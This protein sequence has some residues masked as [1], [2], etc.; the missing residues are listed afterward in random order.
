LPA[1]AICEEITPY[2]QIKHLINHFYNSCGASNSASFQLISLLKIELG[3]LLNKCKHVIASWS[4]IPSDLIDDL[5]EILRQSHIDFNKTDHNG[6][7]TL[8]VTALNA[9]VVVIRKLVQVKDKIALLLRL[10]RN[11]T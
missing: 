2:Q 3:E 9:N 11:F 5:F 7:T 6:W 1:F 10:G 4:D 8:H